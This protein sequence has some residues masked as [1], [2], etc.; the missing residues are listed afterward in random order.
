ML[1]VEG[2]AGLDAGDELHGN[3]VGALVEELEDG[4]LGVRAESAAGD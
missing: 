2:V 3:E 4:V 1:L